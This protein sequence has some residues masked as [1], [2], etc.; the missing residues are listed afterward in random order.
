M[1]RHWHFGRSC[2]RFIWTKNSRKSF[3]TT[4]ICASTCMFTACYLLSRSQVFRS[5]LNAFRGKNSSGNVEWTFSVCCILKLK[6]RFPF[7]WLK[8]CGAAHQQSFHVCK[9]L[10]GEPICTKPEQ[11]QH[12]R[13]QGVVSWGCISICSCTGEPGHPLSSPMKSEK[14]KNAALLW[15]SPTAPREIAWRKRAPTCNK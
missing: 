8:A 9:C 14:S 2:I 6:K 10:P 11:H 1:F 15:K 7:L 13:C 5:T 3:S 4:F 12:Q